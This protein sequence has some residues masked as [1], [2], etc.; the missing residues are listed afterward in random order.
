[1]CD[2]SMQAYSSGALLP[3]TDAHISLWLFINI[4]VVNVMLIGVCVC[5]FVCLRKIKSSAQLVTAFRWCMWCACVRACVGVCVCVCAC[6]C[7]CLYLCVCVLTSWTHNTNDPFLN[8]QLS[9]HITRTT[10]LCGFHQALL[11]ALSLSYFNSIQPTEENYRP[12]I[13]EFNRITAHLDTDNHSMSPL[14]EFVIHTE[15]IPFT[16]TC[17]SISLSYCRISLTRKPLPLP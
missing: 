15:G 16:I 12:S 7:V 8:C 9:P 14:N 11:E 1:M 10:S 3:S 5:C 2:N 13:R 4:H 6:V 17:R